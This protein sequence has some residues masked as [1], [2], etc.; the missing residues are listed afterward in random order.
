MLHKCISDNQSAFVLGRSI[1]DNAMV[2]IE[3]VHYMKS[4]TS[5]K[6]GSVALKLDISKAYDRIDWLYF[7]E[8]MEKMG[9][10]PQWVNWIMMCF[11]TVDYS[12]L[13][14]QESVGP[15][16]SGR[17]LRQGD[18]LFPH[19]FILCAEGLTALI[20]QAEVR[21]EIHGEKIC[22]NAPIISHLL[23]VD[24]CFLFF[25]ATEAEAR[26]IKSILTTY[27]EASGQAISLPK[28]EIFYSRN[29]LNNLQNVVT[30]ILGVQAVLGTGKYLGLPSMIGRNKKATF[31]FI[32]DRI[33]Q[34]INLWSSKCLSKAG[35]E[36]MIKFVLQAIPSYVLSI[37]L[38]PSTLFE[39]IEKMINAL[40]WG[41]GGNSNR[42][43][44]W[45][46]WD[47][48]TVHKNLAGWD[49]KI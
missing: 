18:P 28:S 34:R 2:A 26:K 39:E 23:F 8:V 30:S 35:R 46:S 21:G 12:V 4:K 36:V 15:I 5:S 19:L 32:K 9:F 49:S 33:W 6:E 42:V 11:E 14:N 43:I 13:V 38:L 41:N 10:C 45:L 48:L 1:L 47:K 22:R 27:E 44:H 25:R 31:S 37:F 40:W 24:D 7:K 20:H 3:V 17:G 29:V 16:I